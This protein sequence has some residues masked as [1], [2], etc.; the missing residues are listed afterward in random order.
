MNFSFV[1]LLCSKTPEGKG[2]TLRKANTF[3]ENENL[4]FLLLVKVPVWLL[5]SQDES[6]KPQISVF[7]KGSSGAGQRALGKCTSGRRGS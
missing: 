2:Y 3:L 4:L 7:C 5:A 6:P 1:S